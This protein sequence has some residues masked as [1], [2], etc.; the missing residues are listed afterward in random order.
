M[1]FENNKALM[2]EIHH[3]SDEN[4]ICV[5]LDTVDKI[6]EF[7]HTV[8]RFNAECDLTAWNKR[9]TVDAKSIM[10]IFSLDL[11]RP[12]RLSVYS[13]KPDEIVRVMEAVAPFVMI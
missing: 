13:S 6:K 8:S 9:Y 7:V 2:P 4:S 11:S 3:D 1:Y 5:T 12:V 10:G